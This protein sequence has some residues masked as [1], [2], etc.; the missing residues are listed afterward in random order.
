M[1]PWA[2][3]VHTNH[4]IASACAS[5]QREPVG[6]LAAKASWRAGTPKQPSSH[7]L[8]T[9]GPVPGSSQMQSLSERAVLPLRGYCGGRLWSWTV[10]IRKG[11]GVE[12]FLV[13]YSV[14]KKNCV[15]C[16]GFKHQCSH[17]NLRE[18]SARWTSRKVFSFT[19]FGFPTVETN[20]PLQKHRSDLWLTSNQDGS[21]IF[22]CMGRNLWT[23]VQTNTQLCISMKTKEAQFPAW[24][25]ARSLRHLLFYPKAYYFLYPIYSYQI[26]TRLLYFAVRVKKLWSNP[27]SLLSFLLSFMRKADKGK[28]TANMSSLGF[29]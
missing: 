8:L 25:I 28:D 27:T 21:D 3:S 7:F 4:G 24:R 1:V 11:K 12:A 29:F 2:L 16:M 9:G 18:N 6:Q 26:V 5:W 15:D 22:H 20:Q 19:V 13:Q 23:I 10:T 14:F 17:G